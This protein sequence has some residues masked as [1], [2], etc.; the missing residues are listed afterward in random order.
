MKFGVQLFGVFNSQTDKEAALKKIKAAGYDYV[1]PCV[2]VRRIQDYDD[3]I[4]PM[5]N[6]PAVKMMFD[7]AGL[8]VSSCHIFSED[9]LNDADLIT[10]FG[11]TFGIRQF[12][13]KSPED[14]S[15]ASL[16]ETA[17][18]YRSFAQKLSMKNM[19]LLVRNEAED[20]RTRIDG[21][22]AYEYLLEQC[23]GEVFA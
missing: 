1:E 15:K 23:L 13:V 3:V 10:T 12:V 4:I 5:E 8:S 21:R 2:S 20:I 7:S 9:V 22:T 14:L 6:Y 11:E 16:Q 19:L 18:K 17:F